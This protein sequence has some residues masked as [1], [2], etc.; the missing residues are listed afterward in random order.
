VYAAILRVTFPPERRE[1]VVR[2]LDAEM[3][4]VIRHN[5]GF[6]DFRVLDSQEPGELIM[7]DA[8]RSREDSSRSAPP[9]DLPG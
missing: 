8:W 5:P 4:P 2:F 6:V 3:L 7:I 9:A 1:E